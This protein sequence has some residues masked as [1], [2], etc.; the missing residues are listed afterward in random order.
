[1]ATGV[2]ATDLQTAYNNLC[3]RIADVTANPKVSYTIDGRTYNWTEY[4]A[5]LIQNRAPLKQAIQDELGPFE[6]SMRGVV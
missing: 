4:L 2:P 6:Y 1:M 5:M 3:A